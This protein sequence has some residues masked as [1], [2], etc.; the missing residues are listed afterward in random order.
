MLGAV[1]SLQEESTVNKHGKALRMG[2][3]I[4]KDAPDGMKL[5]LFG[6]IIDK[7]SKSECYK[8]SKRRVEKLKNEEI[9]LK[10]FQ[11]F[12]KFKIQK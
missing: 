10:R 4:I 7:V 12:Q 3:G 6:F 9:K 2:K 8:F 1:Y 11:L 5:I